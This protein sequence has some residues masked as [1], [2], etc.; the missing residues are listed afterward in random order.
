M[1]HEVVY[2]EEKLVAGITVRTSNND[3]D[4]TKI[5]GGAWKRFFE[6]GVYESI[7]NKKNG[8]TIGLYT[9]YENEVYGNYDLMICCEILGEREISNEI[10]VKRISKGKYAKFS[11]RGDAQKAVAQCWTEIWS[12]N[13]D[14]KY[15]FDFE[16]YKV[17][18]GMEDAEI[19]IYISIN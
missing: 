14:R 17:A 16:E 13:L 19:D 7:N 10:N 9:N 3:S 18:N 5:I 12:M 6:N 2:L 15:S 11:V 1:N 8:N 4:M